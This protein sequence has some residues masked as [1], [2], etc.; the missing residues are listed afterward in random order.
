MA[1]IR[2]GS[3]NHN[4]VEIPLNAKIFLSKS[5]RECYVSSISGNTAKVKYIDTGDFK[6]VSYDLIK[7]YL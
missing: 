4:G 6:D 7:R 3:K 1:N 2:C 5:N